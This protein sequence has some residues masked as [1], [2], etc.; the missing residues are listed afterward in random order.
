[1]PKDLPARAVLA[2]LCAFICLACGMGLFWRRTAAAAARVLFAYLLLWLLAFKTRFIFTG[3]LVE[4]SYQSVDG[5]RLGGRGFLLRH[6][7]ACSPRTKDR[8]GAEPELT[9]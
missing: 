1:M 5:R 7:L 4:G 2:Y 3:P 9:G 8:A 6:A